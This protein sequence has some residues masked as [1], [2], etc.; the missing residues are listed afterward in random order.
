MLE[1]RCLSDAEGPGGESV[2]MCV[3][4]RVLVA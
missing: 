3:A 4:Q 2:L 1:P